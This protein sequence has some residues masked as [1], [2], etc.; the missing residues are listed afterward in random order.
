MNSNHTIELGAGA[1]VT[2]LARATDTAGHCGVIRGTAESGVR[3]PA[4]HCHDDFAEVYVMLAG[5]LELRLDDQ[6]R[7]LGPGD[8][9]VVAPGVAHTFRTLE[10]SEWINLWT[11]GGFEQYFAEA[12]AALPDDRPPD[13]GVLGAIAARYGLRAIRE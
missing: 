4:L 10:R 11:P 1:S 3:G 5:R 6:L 12:A 2:V 8:V 13:P 9:A 7:E